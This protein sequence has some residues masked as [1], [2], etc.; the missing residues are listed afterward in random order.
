[1]ILFKNADGVKAIEEIQ[2]NNLRVITNQIITMIKMISVPIEYI[3][4]KN[5]KKNK[6]YIDFL[7]KLNYNS[8]IL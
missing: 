3:V 6:K 8:I 5:I 4:H 7:L 1:M 2:L